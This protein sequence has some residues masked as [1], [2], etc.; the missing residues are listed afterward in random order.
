MQMKQ[1]KD[2]LTDMNLAQNRRNENTQRQWGC[3]LGHGKVHTARHRFDN[4]GQESRAYVYPLTS[5]YG[6]HPKKIIQK[7]KKNVASGE[8]KNVP[9]EINLSAIGNTNKSNWQSLNNSNKDDCEKWGCSKS[10]EYE[11]AMKSHNH[12]D[13]V[14]G[15][16]KMGLI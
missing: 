9:K 2:S 12:K 14:G 10:M 6:T 8:H 1:H 3:T 13:H 7:N 4:K 16:W 5:K 15:L 11:E